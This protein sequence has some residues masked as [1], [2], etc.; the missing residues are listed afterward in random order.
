M[1]S[2]SRSSSLAPL[3]S[4][5]DMEMETEMI[6]KSLNAWWMMTK[7][8]LNLLSLVKSILFSG[9]ITHLDIILCLQPGDSCNVRTDLKVAS[10]GPW[11]TWNTGHLAVI[12]RAGQK[13]TLG[14]EQDPQYQGKMIRFNI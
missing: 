7:H 8:H 12:L 2:A 14:W 4:R 3:P 5:D 6:G 1:D 13:Q 11:L 9:L 10:G